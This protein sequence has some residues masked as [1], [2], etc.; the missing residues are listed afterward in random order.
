MRHFFLDFTGTASP[1]PWLQFKHELQSKIHLVFL[2]MFLRNPRTLNASFTEDFEG[3][4][5]ETLT[6]WNLGES[7]KMEF[8][9][10]LTPC[11]S[12]LILTT[13]PPE[14]NVQ[15]LTNVQHLALFRSPV[16]LDD[17]RTVQTSAFD[18]DQLDRPSMTVWQ[19]SE[20]DQPIRKE[21]V[22]LGEH[23]RDSRIVTLL[24]A[25]V[26]QMSNKLLIS[27]N[28]Y[29]FLVQ[30]LKTVAMSSSSWKDI[31]TAGR[32]PTSRSLIDQLF[33]YAIK[34]PDETLAK[35]MLQIG[36]DPNQNFLHGV[37]FCA[38]ALNFTIQQ[39]YDDLS[40]LLLDSGAVY[41]QTS[42]RHAIL[43]GDL[44][45]ADRMLQSD[46]SLDV[47]FNYIDD[48]DAL[49]I[50]KLTYLN[51][52]TI[53]LLGLVCLR[54]SRWWT[55][56]CDKATLPATNN[57]ASECMSCN[58][59]ITEL[60][61]LLRRGAVITLDTMILA[62]FGAGV[63]TLRFL[64]QQGGSVHGFNYFG[65]SCLDAASLR[66]KLQYEV[67]DLLL[68]SGAPINIPRTHH[69]FG[70][71]ASPFH[72]L[73]LYQRTCHEIQT[74]LYLLVRSGGDIN[75]RIRH[76]CSPSQLDEQQNGFLWSQP[77]HKSTP[78]YRIA[79]AK[80]ESPLECAIIADD[81][82]VALQFVHWGC[83]LTGREIKLAVKF[84]LLRL[85]HA[86][87]GR[88]Q[89]RWESDHEGIRRTCLRLALRWG[90]EKI[91][92]FLLRE[93]VNFGEQ[94]MI[95][96]LQY[97]GISRLATDTQIDLINSTP[98]FDCRKI[99]GVPLLEL[100]FL[101]FSGSAVREILRRFPAA[102][103]SGA[104]SAIV[105]RTLNCN[106]AHEDA[107]RIAEIQTMIGRRTETNCDWEKEN[108]ALL[109]TAMFSS[110]EI[111]RILVVPGTV[112]VM[113]TARLPK[114]DF[115]WILDSQCKINRYYNVDPTHSLGCQDWVTCSPLLGI[116]MTLCRS[117]HWSIAEDIL[118]HMLAC[119]Y[120]PD[121]LTVVVAATWDNILLLRRLRSLDNWLSIMSI[122]S[123][124]RPSWCPTALQVAA[125]DENEELVEFFL[126][127]GV[128]VNE[129]PA[130]E[131]MGNRM[132]RTALQAAIGAGNLRL[133]NLFIERGASIDAPAA[134]DSGATAL[135]LACIQ[136]NFD[137]SLRL[138]ELGADVNAKGALRHGRTALEGAAE[139][140][141]IDTL[142]LLLSHGACTDGAYREQYI[143]AVLYAEKYRHFAAAG[144]LRDH[145]AW[146]FDD[147]EC[148][149]SLQSEKLSDG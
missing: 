59:D 12:D 60:K 139:H 58:V 3:P 114:R 13:I 8:L 16:T 51:L 144:L 99:F 44:S 75:Y 2:E 20:S 115:S 30:T 101:K 116:A 84:G 148:Y 85:L 112:C 80:A 53:N 55:C 130:N 142:Q 65:F 128:S 89:W 91:V 61:Y 131:P 79:E 147:E 33:E 29:D 143:K 31:I 145:R 74:I 125:S 18:A 4:F 66:S 113:K 52:E 86:L 27:L 107:F 42:L 5:E 9:K 64:M 10:S 120:E 25:L 41:G 63:F 119:S 71:Q 122:E 95:D 47:N 129:E 106:P 108:T 67:F 87:L 140:G 54:F 83:E 11:S 118:D 127:E 24:G 19:R 70:Y 97:P 136:G 149:R 110:L 133:T 37:Q 34:R 7:F 57:H 72:Y 105:L 102:Y 38:P 28:D 137:L 76:L 98:D 146:N 81:E 43:S 141:R 15:A 117:I 35:M 88:M 100:C 48:L 78:R 49:T 73:C 26:F 23:P 68:R 56:G 62:S 124:D 45:I 109:V 93:G 138:L 96:A 14:I 92:R 17:L 90:H 50:S 39:R 21:A 77:S 121:A 82:D 6:N 104:L 132:P 1:L 123:H 111:S 69:A 103:D 94:E 134:E 46:P 126:G 32:G 135:Q 40:N 36:A 22:S